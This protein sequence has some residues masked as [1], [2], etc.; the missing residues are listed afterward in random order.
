MKGATVTLPVYGPSRVIYDS[1]AD[2]EIAEEEAKKSIDSNEDRVFA[3]EEE[4]RGFRI[5]LNDMKCRLTDVERKLEDFVS[6]RVVIPSQTAETSDEIQVL[7]ANI[8][9]STEIPQNVVSVP[10]VVAPAE[11]EDA[12]SWQWIT[13]ATARELCRKHPDRTGFIRSVFTNLFTDLQAF[14]LDLPGDRK[15][16]FE[17]ICLCML[18]PSSDSDIK[19][20]E[21]LIDDEIKYQ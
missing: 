5:A 20:V 4:N 9:A 17:R 18:N 12:P 1:I 16:E 3:L 7:R 14:Q 10:R 2:D 19:N 6:G 11:I 21:D 13:E 8:Q 15:A